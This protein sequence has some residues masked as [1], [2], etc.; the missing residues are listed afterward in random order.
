[1]Y[2]ILHGDNIFCGYRPSGY[3]IWDKFSYEN[4]TVRPNIFLS[5]VEAVAE[6]N[7]IQTNFHVGVLVIPIE[8]WIEDNKK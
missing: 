3:L 7:S 1:M 6:G 2:V 8:K 5:E 4:T